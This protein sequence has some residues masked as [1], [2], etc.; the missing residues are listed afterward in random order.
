MTTG[1]ETHRVDTKADPALL[2]WA[3]LEVFALGAFAISQPLYSLL[4]ANATFFAANGITDSAIAWFA[5]AV[6]FVPGVV[7]VAIDLALIFLGG[8]HA[9]RLHASLLGTLA[10]LALGVPLLRAIGAG[11]LVYL[12]GLALMAVGIAWLII[13]HQ[14]LREFARWGIFAPF[15]FIVM[16][17]FA[18]PVSDLI[19]G[20]SDTEA[21]GGLDGDDPSVVMVVFDQLPL[22]M[23]LDEEGGIDADRFPGFARLA[24]RS[25]WYSD[26]TTLVPMTDL[27]VPSLLTGRI[28]E[29]GD[30]P[31]HS[32]HP[33]NMFT[34]LGPSHDVYA[35]EYVTQL[36]PESICGD[37]PKPPSTLWKDTM[38]VL[39]R[40]LLD[41][42]T[43]DAL[44]PRTDG[45]WNDFGGGEAVVDEA[46]NEAEVKAKRRAADD[47]T[48]RFEAFIQGLGELGS[49]DRP[50]VH[51]LHLFHPHEPFRYLPDCVQHN[52][53]GP[54][55]PDEEGTWPDNGP[56][57]D[58]RLQQYLVQTMCVDSEVS[59]I[60]D[61]MDELGTAD[62][63]ILVVTSDHGVGMAPGMPNR[64]ADPSTD[65]TALTE[66]LSVPLFISVPGKDPA[67]SDAKVQL[68]DVLPTLLDEFGANPR[69]WD[70]DGTPVN[71]L[72]GDRRP[73]ILTE[74]G[75]ANSPPRPMA[76][77]S[78]TPRRI[79]ALMPEPR[80]PYLFGPASELFGE[81]APE[82]TEGR[83]RLSADLVKDDPLH[84]VTLGD[85]YAPSVI[86]AVVTGMDASVDVLVVLDGIVAGGGRTFEADGSWHLSV[87]VDPDLMSNGMN[88][89]QL[90]E[91]SG[92]GF[93]PIRVT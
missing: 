6:L 20:G 92:T 55:L 34:I 70:F 22:T 40:T 81:S 63:T 17:L 56:L 38:I 11:G 16:F 21:A 51:Y 49:P 76:Q 86:N 41:E 65:P 93:S 36:C 80:V 54:F 75:T 15:L 89:L 61:R 12:L 48:V 19:S 5:L 31:V 52:Q 64:H 37:S 88:N 26:A 53:G 82:F 47:D 90:V 84:P 13:R 4:G 85:N 50:D 79:R 87:M 8:R 58:Q 2:P 45:R 29:W 42:R 74:D 71:K 72:R 27:A 24:E 28:P 73:L 77:A 62:S 67:I 35:D 14:R 10:A 66:Q 3:P 32:V 46:T 33:D 7:L 68:H 57:M 30:L 25:T 44:V 23:L 69:Q 1:N 91:V 9:T 43:A 39:V 83:S 60:L 18:S 78:P 59:A